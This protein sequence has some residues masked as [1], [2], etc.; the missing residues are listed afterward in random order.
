MK[1]QYLSIALLMLLTPIAQA[2]QLEACKTDSKGKICQS[3]LEGIVD[4]ALMY[5]PLAVGARLESNDYLSRALKYRGGKRFQEANRQFCLDR[6]P[7]RVSLVTG[8][9]EAIDS[10]EVTVQADLQTAVFSLLDC[11]RL[12]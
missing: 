9:T 10:G 12:Q 5:K 11:Q 4:G 2:S 8:L 3:Y 7:E 6:L 1:S